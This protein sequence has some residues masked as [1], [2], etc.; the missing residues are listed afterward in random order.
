MRAAT[1]PP[2]PPR[3]LIGLNVLNGAV[4]LLTSSAPAS[5]RANS[6]CDGRARIVVGLLG[7]R[8][9][10]EALIL[11]RRATRERILAGALVNALHAISMV[12]LARASRRWR[13]PAL[14]SAISA[15][16]LGAYGLRC[17]LRRR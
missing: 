3:V 6:S 10:G 2:S 13:G 9:L 15:S 1:S 8:H 5:G 17:G 4:L 11:V 16:A 12:L 14:G 7:C